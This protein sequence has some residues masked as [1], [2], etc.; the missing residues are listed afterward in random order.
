MARAEIS[1]GWE[2]GFFDLW[3]LCGGA[4]GRHLNAVPPV[5]GDFLSLEEDSSLVA[6][7]KCFKSW[8]SSSISEALFGTPLASSCLSK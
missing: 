5:E 2:K 8:T 6:Y 3:L 7:L 1:L 4:G